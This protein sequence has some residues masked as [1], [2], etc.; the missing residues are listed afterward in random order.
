MSDLERADLGARLGGG[1]PALY[2]VV[3]RRRE[4]AHQTPQQAQR[5]PCDLAVLGEH[6]RRWVV[7]RGYDLVTGAALAID[8]GVL[9]S[10]AAA[11]A[12]PGARP[13]R[14]WISS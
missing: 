6:P 11:T 7:A 4:A 3:G 13:L 5:A 8:A 9:A 10:S 12:P 14:C 2:N 1:Q